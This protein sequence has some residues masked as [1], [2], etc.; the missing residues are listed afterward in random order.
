MKIAQGIGAGGLFGGTML[1]IFEGKIM[2]LERHGDRVFLVQRPHRFTA[3]SDPAARQAV[4]LTFGSSALQSADIESIRDA[5]GALVVPVAAWFVSDLSNVGERVERAAGGNASFEEDLSWVESVK[6]FPENTNIRTRLT[7]QPS[8]PPDLT[9]LPDNRSISV[10]IHY[11]LAAL[12]AQAMTP[13]LGDDRVGSFMTVHKDF[14][15]EDSTF[16]RRYV[17]RWRLER[18][19]R[20]GDRWRPVEPITYYI[21]PN[22]PEQYRAAFKAGVEAWN[23]AFEAAGW[24]GAIRALD[25]PD[26]AD[27]EDIRYATLRWNVSDNSGYGAIGPSVVDPRTGEVL[28]ADILFEASMFQGHRQGWRHLAGQVTAA[29]AFEQALGVAATGA[30]VGSRAAGAALGSN[31]TELYGFAHAFIEQGALLS[32]ALTARG[33]IAAN[34]PVPAEFLNQAAKW[35]VMHEVGHTLGLQHNFRSSASTPFDRLHDRAWTERNG[36]FSSVM[37]YPNVNI[38]PAGQT[39]GYYYNPGV[40]SYDRWAIGYAYTPDDAR[41]AELA[42]QVADPRHLFGTN[43]ESGGS[44][45][46]DPSINTYDLSADPLAWGAERAAI[47]AS[48]WERLPDYILDDNES[49]Y[50]VTSAFRSLLREHSRALAPAVKYIG[51][52]YINRDHAGDPNGRMPFVNVPVDQQRRALALIVERAFEPDA[53]DVPQ[54]VLAHLGSNRWLHWGE[55]NTFGDRLDFPFHEEVV[56]FQS[57]MIRQLLDP[58]RLARIRD[59]ETKFGQANVV[60]IPELMD[61]LTAAIWS[62]VETTAATNIGAIRRDLQRAHLQALVGMVEGPAEGVPNDARAVA[63]MELRRLG[64]ALEARLA[65]AASLDAYTRAHLADAAARIVETLDTNG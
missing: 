52:Q 39:Q 36:V 59:A 9:S 46:L 54:T 35:V 21:D 37:E 4:E 41:A 62:E 33:D 60:T 63:R 40:G 1:D 31:G 50:T 23:G 51:G 5:D 3:V 48:L 17:N 6:S 43:A 53:F 56:G 15:D 34:D 18:G 45:A 7:F 11:T 8:E 42:R 19:E 38:S 55:S 30:A 47:A 26:G 14:S 20:I 16:F 10:S 29:E 2:A 12:P 61:A 28:D 49:Y 32:L 24:E 25:L 58:S 27:P 57:S 22:V 44:G 65:D 13:R 64:D